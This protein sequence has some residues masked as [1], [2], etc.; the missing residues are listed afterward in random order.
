MSYIKLLAVCSIS[1]MILTISYMIA[2]HFGFDLKFFCGSIHGLVVYHC[3][4]EH[5]LRRNEA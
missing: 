2:G 3:L 4:K 5:Y 1:C